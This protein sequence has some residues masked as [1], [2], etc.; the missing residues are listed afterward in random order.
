[1]KYGLVTSED[2]FWNINLLLGKIFSR[3]TKINCL[4]QVN[5]MLLDT[6]DFYYLCHSVTHSDRLNCYFEFIII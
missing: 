6:I 5:C 3:Y 2:I 1:M 4:Q